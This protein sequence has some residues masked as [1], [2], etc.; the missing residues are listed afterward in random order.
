MVTPTLWCGQPL[1][2]PTVSFFGIST[3]HPG[4]NSGRLFEGG[5]MFFWLLLLMS[6]ARPGDPFPI[7][8]Y[9][10][11]ELGTWSVADP[12]GLGRDLMGLGTWWCPDLP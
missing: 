6:M 3:E 10:G 2:M 9:K 7:P 1:V 8:P 5:L 11:G 12:L 4:A